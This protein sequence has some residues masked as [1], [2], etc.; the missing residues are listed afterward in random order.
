MKDKS[1]KMTTIITDKAEDIKD[2]TDEYLDH[3]AT[4]NQ[5]MH[6][7][8]QRKK[9]STKRIPKNVATPFPPLKKRNTEKRWPQNTPRAAKWDAVIPRYCSVTMTAIIPLLIS[10]RRVAIAAILLP[11]LSTLVAPMFP[12]PIFLRFPKPKV[13]VIKI[14]VGID[15]RRYVG[16]NI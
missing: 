6:T 4:I 1:S 3:Q 15:P 16:K 9:S 12:E 7:K 13:L 2:A 11:V 8:V 5:E 14:P 10:K